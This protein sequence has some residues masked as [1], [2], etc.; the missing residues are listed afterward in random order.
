MCL[1]LPVK[2]CQVNKGEMKYQKQ[3][4]QMVPGLPLQRGK[5]AVDGTHSKQNENVWF[6]SFWNTIFKHRLKIGFR[7]DSFPPTFERDIQWFGS[8]VTNGPRP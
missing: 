5:P 3:S 6:S 1:R 4:S 2:L 8:C 7:K